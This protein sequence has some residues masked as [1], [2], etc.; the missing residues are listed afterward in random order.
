[1]KKLIVVCLSLVMML[2]MV[3]VLVHAEVEITPYGDIEFN[4]YSEDNYK[5]YYLVQDA[6][7]VEKSIETVDSGNEDV[8]KIRDYDTISFKVEAVGEGETLIHVKVVYEDSEGYTRWENRSFKVT[9]TKDYM[10]SRLKR[11][12]FISDCWY[13]SKKLTV[14]SRPNTSGTLT[15]GKD[16]F[17]VKFGS[18]GEKTIK[19][20]KLYNLNTKVSFKVTDGGYTA[21]V[22]YKMSSNT[23]SYEYKASKK[24]VKV[25]CFNLHKGDIIKVKYKNRTTTK[26]VKKNYNY[27]DKTYKIYTKRRLTKSAKFTVTI[28]NKKKK[29]LHKIKV[30]LE[31][32][33]M[34]C[35][36]TIGHISKS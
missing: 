25:T 30:K 13:G 28:V 20:K 1:M 9:V 4:K 8:V 10:I 31:N 29:T 24:Y 5:E 6:P 19:L 33:N 23:E 7:S 14:L 17:S 16:K 32:G 15:V 12:M 2:C 34:K 18:S 21:T 26:K 27:K 36:R 3:Q 11:Q 22:N 35:L